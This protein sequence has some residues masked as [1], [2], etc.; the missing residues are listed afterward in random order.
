[1]VNQLIGSAIGIG[2]AAIVVGAVA[3]PIIMGVNTSAVAD[4][5][6]NN[7]KALF[8]ATDKTLFTYIPTFLILALLVGAVGAA[9]YLK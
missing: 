3:V 2:I 7:S 8:S 6:V 9:M 4:P 1:M 5:T